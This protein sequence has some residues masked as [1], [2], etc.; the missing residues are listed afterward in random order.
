MN[1]TANCARGKITD[2]SYYIEWIVSTLGGGSSTTMR[3]LGQMLAALE[4]YFVDVNTGGHSER[5]EAF[6]RGLAFSF[7][8]RINRERVRQRPCDNHHRSA[9]L[10]T[11]H[12]VDAFVGATLPVG[13][14]MVQS[15]SGSSASRAVI[16]QLASMRPDVVL[17]PLLERVNSA[18]ETHREH[19]TKLS[20]SLGN[21]A[22]LADV[23]VDP[24]PRYRQ[25]PT[26]VIPLLVREVS[27]KQE[28]MAL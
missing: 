1:T 20:L 10:L 4:S 21:V 25:G 11:E 2:I 13:L 17:P 22:C 26:H 5:L 9:A 23:L 3:H 14:Q 19:P 18:L 24:G 8:R 12:D 28:D 16:K 6:V 15:V 7:V 27:F